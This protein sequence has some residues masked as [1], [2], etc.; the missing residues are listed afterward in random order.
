[1]EVNRSVFRPAR[2]SP[3][4]G[5]D[6]RGFAHPPP[7]LETVSSRFWPRF[8]LFRCEHVIR[9]SAW[10]GRMF[11]GGSGEKKVAENKNMS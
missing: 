7:S 11:L 10:G 9:L 2:N 1:M 4:A 5:P 6:P 8:G 3:P